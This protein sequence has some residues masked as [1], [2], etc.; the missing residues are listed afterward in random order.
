[1]EKGDEA[2]TMGRGKGVEEIVTERRDI[3]KESSSFLYLRNTV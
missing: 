1:M 3:R 2:Q